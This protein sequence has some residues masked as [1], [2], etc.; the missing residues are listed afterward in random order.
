TGMGRPAGRGAPGPRAA[1]AMGRAPRRRFVAEGA[2]VVIADLNDEAGEG[3]AHALGPA[4]AYRHADVGSLADL[5]AAVAF[6]RERF[7]GLDVMH[8]NA[9]MSGGGYVAEMDTEVWAPSL[10][11]MLTGV[12]C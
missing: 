8:N 2:R 12:F 9:A 6:A 5:E 1:A 7:G 3:A 4:A 10:R 11:C